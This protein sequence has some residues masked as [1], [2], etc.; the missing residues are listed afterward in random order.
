MVNHHFQDIFHIFPMVNH[1]FP[2]G[3]HGNFRNLSIL[4]QEAVGASSKSKDTGT[5]A[6]ASPGFAPC[7]S[8]WRYPAFNMS[9]WVNIYIKSTK[10]FISWV[11]F[12]YPHFLSDLT[13]KMRDSWSKWCVNEKNVVHQ[14]KYVYVYVHQHHMCI[15][16]YIYCIYVCV[17]Y[18]CVLCI[19]MCVMCIYICCINIYTLG[20]I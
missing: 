9:G 3:G 18:M 1:H 6:D 19:Y 8:R 10:F 16:I 20:Y 11:T 5:G 14:S 17:I 15:Y 2:H 7:P 13:E 12:M 4:R